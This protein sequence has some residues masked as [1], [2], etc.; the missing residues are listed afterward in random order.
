M[1]DMLGILT[2]V[3]TAMVKFMFTGLVSYGLGHSFWQTVLYMAIGG[4]LGMTLFYF[5]GA[6]VLEWFRVRYIK[7]SAERKAQG[8]PRKKIFTR[9]NRSIVKL[10]GRYG[11]FGLAALA[12]PTLSIPITAVIAA[13]YFRHDQRTLPTLLVS[14]LAWSFVLSVMWSFVR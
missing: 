2:V 1:Q 14:V 13:K 3:A 6:R 4:C 5:A 11:L 9:T 10:K 12:P 8:L 7:R